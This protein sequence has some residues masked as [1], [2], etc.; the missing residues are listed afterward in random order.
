LT[1]IVWDGMTLAADKRSVNSGRATTVT[2][3][4]R[5]ND[6]LVGVTGDF[7]RGLELVEWFKAGA[8]P[9]ALPAFQRSN[10]DYV[11]MLVV[12]HSGV[13]LYEQALIPFEVEEPFFAI[14]SGRDCA[15]TALHLGYS[16][17]EAVRITCELR[18]CCGNGIDTLELEVSHNESH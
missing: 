14:G 3:I 5:V 2:K 18:T 9:S 16:A 7:A 13:F 8:V 15:L 6:A 1:I 11:P 10:D 17:R 12:R 4:F